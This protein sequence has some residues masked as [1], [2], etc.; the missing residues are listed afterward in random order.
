ML[1]SK[2]HRIRPDTEAAVK[3]ELQLRSKRLDVAYCMLH[4]QSFSLFEQAKLKI[5]VYN[6]Y[7]AER[8]GRARSPLSPTQ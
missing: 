2:P 3:L 4:L 1:Y 7:L 8:T 6:I 5:T